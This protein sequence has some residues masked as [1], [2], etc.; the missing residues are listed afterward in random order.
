[1]PQAPPVRFSASDR[2]MWRIEHDAVLRSPIV[3]IGLLDCDPTDKAVRATFERAVTRVPRL[4]QRVVARGFG[5]RTLSW[6]DDPGFSL[7]YHLRRVRAPLPG[8]LR[9]VLD[10]AA[11]WTAALFDTAR[12]PWECTIVEGVEG[13]R[14]AF[15]LRFHHTLTDGVGGVDLAGVAFDRERVPDTEGRAARPPANSAPHDAGFRLGTR[16]LH[17]G[18]A[19]LRAVASPRQTIGAG[20]HLGRSLRKLLAPAPAPMSP[21]WL[22][23]GLGR[24]LG[25]V[26]LPLAGLRD[27]AR[28]H[29]G[30]INDLFL[31]ALGGGLH[32]FH[33]R[34][35]HEVPA[36]RVTMPIST[37]TK[38]HDPGGNHFVPVRF[39][40]PIDDPDVATRVH[41][42][43]GIT[44]RW[45]DEP[46]L[47][48]TAVIA[49][50]LDVLPGPVVTNVFSAMLRNVDVDAVDVPGLRQPA[51]VGGAE[52][53]RLW[54]FAPPTGAAISVTLLSH[55]DTACIGIL[56]DLAAVDDPDLLHHCLVMAFD[57]ALGNHR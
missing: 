32:D 36:L 3:A 52:I 49:Q 9:S 2:L 26:E 8:D 57:E 24:H 22:D 11:P 18:T 25:V 35:G 44:R 51:F 38:D 53:E 40:L 1:M 27:A 41:I 45:R 56:A 54:A 12:P 50:A 14:A 16:A 7:D 10:L 5:N 43:Q 39:V 19:G 47:D 15:V 33:R 34:L 21:A 31:A 42:A 30:T 6:V 29:G 4:R 20:V 17:L 28:R 13:G 55:R 46:A 23:R 37:R 48:L